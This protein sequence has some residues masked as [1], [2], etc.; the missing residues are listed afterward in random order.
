MKARV[1]LTKRYNN[2]VAWFAYFGV[3]DFI[4]MG[5]QVQVSLK[6][7]TIYCSGL[8]AIRT[9]LEEL[10]EFHYNFEYF[11]IYLIEYAKSNNSLL[12]QS[13]H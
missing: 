7:S 6:M 3:V 5:S 12:E 13:V 11:S 1:Y 8:F 2:V 4:Q 10:A 9:D